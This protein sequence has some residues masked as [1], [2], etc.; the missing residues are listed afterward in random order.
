MPTDHFRT[1][2]SGD[3]RTSGLKIFVALVGLMFKDGGKNWFL[4]NYDLK[5]I[6]LFS[7]LLRIAGRRV[8]LMAD[9]K[10]DDRQ[11]SACQELLKAIALSVYSGVITCG[12]RGVSYYKFLGFRKRLVLSGYNSIS[13][14]RVRRQAESGEGRDL[15]FSEKPFICVARHVEKKGLDFLLCSYAKYV[16]DVNAPRKLILC[17]DGPLTRELK[18]LAERL[19][20]VDLVNFNGF[21]QSDVVCKR[22]SS[23]CCLILPSKVEQYGIAIAE[24]LSL[25][26]PVIATTAC[27]ATDALVHSGV[28]GFLCEYGNAD[29][30]A[31]YMRLIGDDE[32]RW[33]SFSEK[34]KRSSYDIDTRQFF[35]AVSILVNG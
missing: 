13:V 6:M 35:N 2:L 10:F 20:L 8:F 31:F 24:A 12:G 23:S 32:V 4:C 18:D 3:G 15:I 14:R 5:P 21:E 28:N 17:G 22:I 33:Q 19:G 26:V 16:E 25:G 30:L 11:R 27:G 7:I 9:S 1:V 29:G 34:A